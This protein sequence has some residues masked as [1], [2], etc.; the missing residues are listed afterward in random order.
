M[1][2]D[3]SAVLAL[4]STLTSQVAELEHENA[5]LREALAERSD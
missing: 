2:I 4:I 5:Q 3:P 1:N